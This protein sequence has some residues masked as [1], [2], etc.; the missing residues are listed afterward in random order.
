MKVII[1]E[2]MGKPNII[3]LRGIAS[4]ILQKCYSLPKPEGHE[5]QK[6]RVTET[7]AKNKLICQSLENTTVEDICW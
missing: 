6:L 1:T 2:M 4:N 7:A 5:I 3:T